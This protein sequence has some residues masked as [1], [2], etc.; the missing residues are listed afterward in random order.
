MGIPRFRKTLGTALTG[1]LISSGCGGSG[2]VPSMGPA[3]QAAASRIGANAKVDD[4]SGY[5]KGTFADRTSGT[6]KAVA[7]YA[8]YQSAVGGRLTIA[9][10]KSAVIASVALNINASTVDGTTVSGANSHYCTYSTTSTYDYATKTLSGS[11]KA[12]YPAAC[13][14]DSGTFKLHHECTYKDSGEFD[15]R[16][17]VVP[18]PC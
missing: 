4:L 15:L 17:E 13:E 9:Y 10:A 2:G 18:H 1:L 11:Y 6:G 3:T 12:L 7:S 16:R 8:Q 5:Y 14:G